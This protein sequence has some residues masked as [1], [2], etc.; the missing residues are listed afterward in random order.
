MRLVIAF[1]MVFSF[2]SYAVTVGMIDMQKV[3]FTIDEGK[4]VRS[5][6]E[7]TF[8]QKKTQLKKEEDKLKKAK[9]DFDKQVSVLSEKA[10]ARKQQELQKML[11]ALENTRQKFQAEISKLEKELTAPIL[12]KI[13]SVVEEASKNRKVTMSFEKSTAPILYAEKTVDLT[14]DVIKLHNKKHPVK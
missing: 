1:L 14:D 3:L 13:K 4:K 10:R 5:R 2:S 6:L 11:L 8:N 12:Q 7:K 9:E